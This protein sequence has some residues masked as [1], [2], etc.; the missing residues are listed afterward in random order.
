MTAGGGT[1]EVKA[2]PGNPAPERLPNIPRQVILAEKKVSSYTESAPSSHRGYSS[3]VGVSTLFAKKP[4]NFRNCIKIHAEGGF[5]CLSAAGVGS[6][7]A[8]M[9]G[10]SEPELRL[11]PAWPGSSAPAGARGCCGSAGAHAWVPPEGLSHA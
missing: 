9:A 8:G 2:S 5:R 11:P 4:E 1:F 7:Q 10:S 3:L 6:G